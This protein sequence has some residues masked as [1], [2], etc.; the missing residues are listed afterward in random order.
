MSPYL[1]PD[2]TVDV[3]IKYDGNDITADC[4]VTDCW[5]TAR[6]SGFPGEAQVVIRD[7][8]QLMSFT[9]GKTLEL[10]L[11]GVRE[12]DGYA[13]QRKHNY[14]F[15]G[16]TA[17]CYPCP[18]ITPRKHILIGADRNLLFERRVLYNKADPDTANDNI[19]P[20]G[21]SDEDAIE[22]SISLYL[23]DV[24]GIDYT[25]KVETVGSPDPYVEFRLPGP[26]SMFGL[27]MRETAES[28]GAIFYIDPDRYLVYTDVNEPD[29]PFVL[30]DQPTTVGEVGY[31]EMYLFHDGTQM[32]NDALIWGAGQGSPNIV[33][34]RLEDDASIELHG[35]WQ[36]PNGFRQ[37]V[38][39]QG[40]VDRIADS[41]I[42]GS[43]SS[44]RGHKDDRVSVE[45]KVFAPGL[46]VAHK[47]DFT[48][49]AHGFTDVIPVRNMRISFPT[50][51]NVMYELRLSHEL[52]EPWSIVEPYEPEEPE[53][54][55]TPPPSCSVAPEDAFKNLGITVGAGL[56]PTTD[57]GLKGTQQVQT[58]NVTDHVSIESGDGFPPNKW[59]FVGDN[60][61]ESAVGASG[62]PMV[63]YTWVFADKFWYNNGDGGIAVEGD[64][65]HEWINRYTAYQA[66]TNTINPNW[67]V[68]AVMDVSL[69]MAGTMSDR[70]VTGQ[71]FP[72][73][74]VHM[75]NTEPAG[76]HEF[77][78]GLLY[79]SKFYKE[80][81]TQPAPLIQGSMES[82][83]TI[84]ATVRLL[85]PSR[86][87]FM[88]GVDFGEI[89]GLPKW[90]LERVRINTSVV[91]TYEDWT[92]AG[93]ILIGP[94]EDGIPCSERGT[95]ARICETAVH[96]SGLTYR[97]RNPYALG[98][99]RVTVDGLT[100]S[101]GGT[102]Y[103]ESSPQRGE[104]ELVEAPSGD[105]Y[106]CYD[107]SYYT[108]G[109]PAPEAL[110]ILPVNNAPITGSFGSMADGW[111]S[112]YW[113]GSYYE[114][115]HN[116]VDFGVGIGT[117]VYAAADGS[118]VYEDQEAGGM[119]IHIYHPFYGFRT[120]YAHLSERLVANGASVLQGQVIAYSGDSGDVTGPH[121]HWGLVCA[122]SAENPLIYCADQSQGNNPVPPRQE[123]L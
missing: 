103:A 41:I 113:H 22:E 68:V 70:D 21:T 78:F 32:V 51:Y 56:V 71:L 65:I 54:G 105:V 90:W 16:H 98:T 120:T 121:L 49:E 77:M 44:K 35:R 62:S 102:D 5:F 115:F 86:N 74:G 107:S 38:W 1:K 99:T 81:H 83:D 2:P 12:W 36:N 19:W 66:G 116:G 18:H 96:L 69:T 97:V 122:G 94:D 33:F 23:D 58:G 88:L 84:E 76:L 91:I 37:Q 112:Y 8:A 48:N 39:H 109:L 123:V 87:Y 46:R 50:P 24:D 28:V 7:D 92:P 29:A 73:P 104:I 59:T 108:I 63:E 89:T 14:W 17:N 61:F 117:P 118:V 43:P 53:R 55:E 3:Q 93:A 30:T 119:M 20:A 11:D 114:H 57:L 80:P 95:L 9:A 85:M 47:V 42:N 25:T 67:P 75:N 79:P 64:R 60:Y 106:V 31:R 82:G 45:C 6:A 72:F 100:L 34:S 26:T 13:V 110:F 52:D 27:M 10:F 40:S 4:V 15:E 101:G 111:P